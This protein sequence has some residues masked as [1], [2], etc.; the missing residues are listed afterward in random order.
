MRHAAL[1]GACLLGIFAAAC[2]QKTP[3]ENTVTPTVS[4]AELNAVAGKRILFAHQSVG[5]DIVE[6]VKLL[7]AGSG[8]SLE[9]V[10]TRQPADGRTGLFHFKAGTN[11]DPL[12]KLRDF[13]KTVN[14]SA[15]RG[16]DIAMVKF[17]YIDFD[18][19]TDGAALARSYID[20]LERLQSNFPQTRFV[21]IT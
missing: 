10:E 3:T 14:E 5:N 17:C 19:N 12:G 7:V 4:T 11:G 18:A 15:A 16:F 21:A 8:A 1:L 13:E 9:V 6:G 2:T 20:T